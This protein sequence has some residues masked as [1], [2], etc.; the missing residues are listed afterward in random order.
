MVLHSPCCV[1][2]TAVLLT[3]KHSEIH[4]QYHPSQFNIGLS[5]K[6]HS[7]V[8]W[9]RPRQ[10]MVYQGRYSQ[11]QPGTARYIQ[12][13][14]G[15]SRYSQM[16]LDKVDEGRWKWMQMDA[17]G[18][19]WMKLDE[20]EGLLSPMIKILVTPPKKQPNCQQICSFVTLAFAAPW[21]Q[22]NVHWT[23]LSILRGGIFH[24]F[25]DSG[26]CKM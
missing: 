9:N 1:I 18:C 6:Q 10:S 25:S 16:N 21:N 12:V 5:V 14:L 2:I 11:V 15:T 26:N 13:Q 8:I 3:D 24:D 22:V 4:S 17:N 23:I 7:I 20:S 19:Y